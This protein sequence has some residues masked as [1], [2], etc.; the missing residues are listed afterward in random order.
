MLEHFD[1][2]EEEIVNYENVTGTFAIVTME[3][4]EPFVPTDEDEMSDIMLWNLKQ[5]I[6]YVDEC[7]RK[8]VEMVCADGKRG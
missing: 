6:G 1:I 3:R 2:K 7:D 5:D 8:I 4:L